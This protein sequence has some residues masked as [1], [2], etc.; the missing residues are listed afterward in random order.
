MQRSIFICLMC[1]FYLQAVGQFSMDNAEDIE[2]YD[3]LGTEI[4]FQYLK[5]VIVKYE[6]GE[7]FFLRI[8]TGTN[9]NGAPVHLLEHVKVQA[10]HSNNVDVQCF[11][12]CVQL[13]SGVEIISYSTKI[14]TLSTEIGKRR[15]IKSH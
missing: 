3:N 2:I 5:D 7:I 15:F 14:E 6:K 1:L 9:G 13:F 10:C 8:E 11:N 4:P 12:V